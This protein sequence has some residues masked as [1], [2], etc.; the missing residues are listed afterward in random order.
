MKRKNYLLVPPFLCLLVILIG[1]ANSGEALIDIDKVLVQP[2]KL[3][4]KIIFGTNS[5]LPAPKTYYSKDT[6]ST[7]VVELDNVKM[8]KKPL[9]Q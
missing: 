4:T 7:I 9:I 6:P 8:T 2:G 1:Y 3:N 5:P